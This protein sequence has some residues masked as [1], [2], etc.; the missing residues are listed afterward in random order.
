MGRIRVVGGPYLA[1]SGL[2]RRG[3]GVRSGPRPLAWALLG[4]P[5]GAENTHPPCP[6]EDVGKDQP[7]GARGE[8]AAARSSHGFRHGLKDAA[9]VAG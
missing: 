8:V 7:K 4:R 6:A 9:P 2:E 1:P 3:V 5:V